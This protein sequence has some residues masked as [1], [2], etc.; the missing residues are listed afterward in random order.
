MISTENS[1]IFRM[2]L[3]RKYNKNSIYSFTSGTDSTPFIACASELANACLSTSCISAAESVKV[4]V[5]PDIP[6]LRRIVRVKGSSISDTHSLLDEASR[7][8]SASTAIRESVQAM[9]SPLESSAFSALDDFLSKSGGVP[10]YW[11]GG[12]RYSLS[13]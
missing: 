1:I 7:E 12:V 5:V 3:Y 6:S 11:S 13:L 4:G 2:K 10:I 8:S 9:Q